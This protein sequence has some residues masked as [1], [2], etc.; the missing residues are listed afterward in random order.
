VSLPLPGRHNV[1]NALAAFIAALALS[2]VNGI[3][4]RVQGVAFMV[5]GVAFRVQG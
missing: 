1:L 2:T 3:E 5:Q 4:F